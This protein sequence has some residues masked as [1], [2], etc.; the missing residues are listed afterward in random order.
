MMRRVRLRPRRAA[1]RRRPPL[2]AQTAARR[3]RARAPT[4]RS[5]ARRWRRPSPAPAGPAL[6]RPA[7]RGR[8][9]LPPEGLRR[10]H[11]PRAA[12]PAAQRR[13]VGAPPRRRARAR[14]RATRGAGRPGVVIE[15]PEG[16]F[17]VRRS[18]SRR[19]ASAR[20]K[21]RWRPRRPPCATWR[22]RSASGR[23][24]ARRSC[25]HLRL[26]EQQAE[27]FR[28]KRS[29]P[30]A[31]WSARSGRASR[32]LRP[33]AARR[34]VAPA[35]PRA[36]PP[37]APAAARRAEA[38]APGR[39]EPPEPPDAPPPPWR[40]WFDD[41][42]DEARGRADADPTRR[43]RRARG[44]SWPGSRPIAAR[45][46]SLRPEDFVTV[47]VDFVP[48]GSSRSAPGAHAPR[49]RARARPPGAAGR[50]PHR[51]RAAPAARVRGELGG[52]GRVRQ[53]Q[54]AVSTASVP[55]VT[56]NSRKRRRRALLEVVEH[57][58]RR[59]QRP[60]PARPRPRGSRGAPRRRARPRS[61]R[62]PATSVKTPLSCALMSG[63]GGGAPDQPRQP[64]A[65]TKSMGT[66]SAR[67]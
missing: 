55:S 61:S 52:R 5:C 7:A 35:A 26:V 54:A 49:A 60:W 53:Q 51:G 45:S 32:R 50:P 18:R 34:A 21:R 23:A 63:T 16:T 33:P 38:P 24:G 44:A 42:T 28:R 46:S 37:P 41:A 11:R 36:R 67:S 19:S 30:G 31:R 27:A 10:R 3:G 43:G 12:R 15:I 13:V 40:F 25:E 65:P 57:E 59:A 9:R 66:A 22:P 4:S 48:D 6:V 2:P 20:W 47:A 1:R 39:P 56:A 62:R 8:P 29:A 64:R 58:Q 14:P 17:D